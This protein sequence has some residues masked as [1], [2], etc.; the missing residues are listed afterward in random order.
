MKTKTYILFAFCCMLLAVTTACNDYLDITPEGQSKRDDQLST[1][2]GIEDAMYGVYSQLKESRLYGRELSYS[3]VDVMAQYFQSYGNTKVN[4]LLN[5]NYEHSTLISLFQGVWTDMYKNISNVNSVLNS[6]L[7]ENAT[8]YPY[9]IY[10]GEA[11]ALRAM[12]HFDLLRLY[13]RQIT[14]TPDADGIP[15]ATEFSLNT[16]DFIKASKD[17]EL[18]MADLKM[19]ESLLADEADYAGKTKFMTMRQ[20]HLNIHAVRALIARVCLTVGDYSQAYEYAQKVINESGKVLSQTTAINGSMA[21]ILS[22]KETLFG[23]YSATD[24][25]DFVYNDLWLTTSFYSLNPRNDY[26]AIY[27]SNGASDYRLGAFFETQI[28]GTVRFIKILDKYK[29][30]GTESKRPSTDVQGINMIRL[31]EMYYIVAE[32]AAC[33]GQLSIAESALN[34]VRTSRGLTALSGVATAEQFISE[35]NDERYREFIGEGQTFFNLKRQNLP[36]KALD[37][38]QIPASDK[39]YVVPIPDIEYEYR[40]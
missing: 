16:P 19:A 1:A 3:A 18:I 31:P 13:T 33:S 36:I 8:E 12:M 30:D 24:F 2:S 29:V 27:E 15:Y 35:I 40:D 38:S 5:Y 20:I 4:A 28:T 25:Y 11:L 9:K 17:Y 32:C 23:I 26:A 10:R 39:I 21:G 7:I 37:G 6:P 34:A 22:A 14:I